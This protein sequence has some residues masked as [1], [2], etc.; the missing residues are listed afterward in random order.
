YEMDNINPEFATADATIVVGANDVT[1]PAAKET[2]GTPI[3]GMPVLDV[4]NCKN[5]FIFNYDLKPGYAG[6]ENPIYS[7]KNGVHLYL[8]NAAETLA[9]FIEDIK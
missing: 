3:S 1:N 6:V 7:R 2:K 4:N 9:K 5:I 8:G